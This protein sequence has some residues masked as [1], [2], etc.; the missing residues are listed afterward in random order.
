MSAVAPS[1]R[2]SS[3]PDALRSVEESP[4][5]PF[6]SPEREPTVAQAARRASPGRRPPPGRDAVSSRQVVP[7]RSGRIIHRAAESDAAVRRVG[8]ALK[9]RLA[10][11][12]PVLSKSTLVEEEKMGKKML[13]ESGSGLLLYGEAMMSPAMAPVMMSFC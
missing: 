7:S 10:A 5:A 8:C 9:V 1:A 4:M 2:V 12:L 13:P 3:A 11:R 6:I